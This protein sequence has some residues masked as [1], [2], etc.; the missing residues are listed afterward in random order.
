MYGSDQF[1]YDFKSALSE[2]RQKAKDRAAAAVSL[3]AANGREYLGR[4]GASSLAPAITYGYGYPTVAKHGKVIAVAE[5]TAAAQERHRKLFGPECV[6]I[7]NEQRTV[8]QLRA[9]GLSVREIARIHGISERTAKARL[10][11]AA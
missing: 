8:A 3:D 7:P 5:P 6:E 11:L 1:T 10:R 2:A 4:F 9:D